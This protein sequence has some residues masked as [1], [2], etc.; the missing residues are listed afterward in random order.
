MTDDIDL[1]KT[2]IAGLDL[3]LNHWALVVLDGKGEHKLTYYASSIKKLVNSKYAW[4]IPKKKKG[5][6]KWLY[7]ARRRD[8]LY[9]ML[10]IAFGNL[11]IYPPGNTV[12]LNIEHYA[13]GAVTNSAYETGEA[14]G[15]AR[16][17]A[18]MCNIAVRLTDPQSLK[19]FVEKGG[20]D[21][22]RMVFLA[23]GVLIPPEV[24]GS[25]VE[26]DMCD[27][28]HLARLLYTELQLRT[29][30]ITLD[31]LPQNQVKVFNRCTKTFSTNVLA[32][33]FVWKGAVGD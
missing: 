5:E 12:Y 9:G 31:Q 7:N 10:G 21:K 27:A 22:E 33:D 13:L 15:L 14:G 3:S 6:S 8:A 30:V 23:D 19:M 24:E 11:L 28:W 16:Q 4:E 26:E 25:E 1:A 29:G 17:I 32:R 20:I 2:T 18:W